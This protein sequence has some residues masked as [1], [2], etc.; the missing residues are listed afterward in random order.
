MSKSKKKQEKE[1]DGDLGKVPT[2]SVKFTRGELAHIRDVFSVRLPPDLTVTVSESVAKIYERDVLESKLW[3]KLS[4]TMEE[5]GVPTGDDSPDFTI[6]FSG[7]PSLT[8]FQI[9]PTQQQKEEL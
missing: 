1:L 7:P 9:E 4:A 8:V 3:N 5:A 6:M 2:L